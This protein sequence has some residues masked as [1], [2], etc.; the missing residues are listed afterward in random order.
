MRRPAY[1][2][3]VFQPSLYARRIQILLVED[4][5]PDAYLHSAALW[6]AIPGLER[7]SWRRM[8][9]EALQLIDRGEVSP[10]LAIVDLHMPR[11]NGFEL[12]HDFAIRDGARFP[13][14]VLTSSASGA[15]A[16]ARGAL[17]RGGICHQTHNTVEKAG[18]GFGPRGSL[19]LLCSEGAIRKCVRD[20]L[21]FVC[22]QSGPISPKT[23]INPR[24]ASLSARF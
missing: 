21:D 3:N 11:K 16:R 24:R 18:G 14:V 5:E 12:M 15:D 19:T 8:G 17:R 20:A 1:Y 22:S 7:L 13:S 4:D 2:T 6:P 10:D 9:V 23:N